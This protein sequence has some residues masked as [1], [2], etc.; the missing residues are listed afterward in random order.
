MTLLGGIELG[1]TKIVC[2][3]GPGDSTI[4]DQVRFPTG[5]DPAAAMRRAADF[6]SGHWPLAA[7]GVASFG[8]CDWDGTITTTPKPGWQGAEVVGLLREHLP[9]EVPIGFDTDVNGAALGEVRYGA[10][11][12][13]SVGVYLTIGTGLGGGAVIGGKPIHGLMHPEMGH[14]AV[15]RSSAELPEFAGVCP[16]HGDCWEGMAAGPAIGARWGVPAP[17]LPADHPAWALEADYLATGIADLCY[18]L[19]PQ[20]VVLGGGVGLRPGLLEQ[21]VTRLEQRMRGY[22]RPARL[23]RAELGGNAGPVGALCLAADA[24]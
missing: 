18:V 19:S 5:D 3:V 1:G 22:G 21:V 17:E 8:P 9:G 15:R 13:T 7:V 6:L 20:T 4:L 2:V 10:A 24:R 14:V 23:A 16:F 11:R 12:G